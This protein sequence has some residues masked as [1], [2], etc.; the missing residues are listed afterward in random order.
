MFIFALLSLWYTTQWK[1]NTL[2]NLGID[3]NSKLNLIQS[4]D[5][6]TNPVT[7]AI[8]QRVTEA[9]ALSLGQWSS[10]QNIFNSSI[11]DILVAFSFVGIV[12]I[13]PSL[14]FKNGTIYSLISMVIAFVSFIVILTLFSI[15]LIHQNE[16]VQIYRSTG[17]WENNDLIMANVQKILDLVLGPT[18]NN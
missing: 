11:I 6:T 15:C 4:G 2:V 10:L 16:V 3:L 7:E 9:N 14:V 17:S 1:E 8:L 12:A 18:T 13:I 5:G